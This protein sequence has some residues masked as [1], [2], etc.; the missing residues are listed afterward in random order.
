MMKGVSLHHFSVAGD[1][2]ILMAEVCVF[3]MET[4]IIYGR[5][6]RKGELA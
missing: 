5:Y 2:C 4:H 1:E 6:H 3:R